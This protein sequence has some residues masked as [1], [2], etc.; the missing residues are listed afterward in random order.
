MSE[1]QQNLLSSILTLF[2]VLLAGFVVHRFF[3]SLLWAGVISAA[4]M[5]LYR[6]WRA[7]FKHSETVAALLFTTF[8]SIG[9]ILPISWL[10]TDLVH[11]THYFINTVTKINHSGAPVPSAISGL[12][13]VGDELSRYWQT[14][15]AKPGGLMHWLGSMQLSLASLSQLVQKVGYNLLQRGVQLGFTL[16]TLFFF[17][18]DG[19]KLAAQI[20]IVGEKYLGARW[21]HYASKF[22]GA[23]RAAVNGSVV[24]GLGVG[25]IMGA[26]Y[27]LLGFAAPVLA[28]FFT[29]VAA[30][31]PFVVPIVFLIVAAFLFIEGSWIASLIVIVAG[32]FV[33]FLAD[34]IVKPALIGGSTKLPFLMVLFAILGG[35]ETLG[36]LGLFL[37]PIIMVMFMTLWQ[38]LLVRDLHKS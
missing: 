20:Q 11:E 33:M 15:F 9:L 14:H 17:Y 1:E 32:T 30:M 28:G 38:E 2:I 7:Y 36:I 13:V 3:I 19:Q 26:L 35:V 21:R 5:P 8:I 10:I 34:H 31:I 24:V 23:L 18:R 22:P 29:A 37:G 12:P 27:W 16:L 25:L 6:K 4:T